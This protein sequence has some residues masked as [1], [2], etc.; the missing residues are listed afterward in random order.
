MTKLEVLAVVAALAVAGVG[1]NVW[2]LAQEAR[3]HR[4]P[5]WNATVLYCLSVLC[6]LVVYA[7]AVVA[8]P[9]YWDIVLVAVAAA[10]LVGTL[11]LLRRLWRSPRPAT[12]R[13]ILLSSAAMALGVVLLV[14]AGVAGVLDAAALSSTAPE[15]AD[16]GGGVLS[17]PVI[18]QVFWGSEWT[19]PGLPTVDAAVDFEAALPHATWAR[20]VERSG[21]GVTGFGAGGCWIDPSDPRPGTAVTSTRAGAFRDELTAVFTS[22]HRVL[23]CSSDMPKGP[24]S[25]LPADAVVVLWLA[26]GVAFHISGVAAHGTTAWSGRNRGMI[27]AGLPGGYAYWDLPSCGEHESCRAIPPYAAPTY[28]LSHEVLEAV[29]NPYGSGWF[30][31]APLSWSADYVLSNGPTTLLGF[32]QRP[33]Y[34]GEVADLCEPGSLAPG[35]RLQIGQL[36]RTVPLPVAAFYRPGSGCTD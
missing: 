23:A 36:D 8:R 22:Q 5:R 14:E 10:S 15:L 13:A 3:A 20:A 6:A 1:G 19:H 21:F 29:T 2:L 30:A 16:H 7:T 11:K 17:S 25:A 31:A 34:P 28:A 32:G 26:P 33:V 18:Y 24:P 35:Q 4:L 9:W 12:L 27:V